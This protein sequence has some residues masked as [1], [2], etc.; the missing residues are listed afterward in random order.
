MWQELTHGW[1]ELPD[2][3]ATVLQARLLDDAVLDQAPGRRARR[4]AAHW[5]LKP[6]AHRWQRHNPRTA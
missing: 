1:L 3:R 4:R 6:A 2:L 5:A